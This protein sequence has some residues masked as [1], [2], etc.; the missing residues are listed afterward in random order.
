MKIV[1]LTVNYSLI[2]SGGIGSYLHTAANG[3]VSYGH[4]VTVMS[5]VIVGREDALYSVC[6]I[7]SNVD[8]STRRIALSKIFTHELLRLNDKTAI[9]I[10]EATD[11]GM[12]GYDCLN[13]DEFATIIRLHTPNS[14]VDE[15]NGY[16]RLKDSALVNKLE[17]E[18]FSKANYL[19]SPS[20]AMAVLA[21][22][23]W[24]V[25]IGKI[26]VIHNPVET[27][28]S[29]THRAVGANSGVIR[30]GFLGRLE[31]R[32]GVYVLAEALRSV[33]SETNNLEVCF[34]GPDTRLGDGS[35]GRNLRKS[36][37]PYTNKVQFTG[38]LGGSRKQDALE[39][40]D[41]I[42]LP[43]LWENFPYAC[44]EAMAA[45]KYVI[46]TSGSG[47]EEMITPGINGILV[48]PG[49]SKA[50][51]Q[52]I[53]DSLNRKTY[54]IGINNNEYVNNFQTKNIIPKMVEYYQ[55]IL[56]E[57]GRR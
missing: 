21:A 44:L 33:F 4:D 57:K 35:V 12:E 41:M 51:S 8:A 34:I 54:H 17:G 22:K 38:H 46:A 20:K 26:K 5:P 15:L 11:W 56:Q 49:D 14:V 48:S 53:I 42:V 16:S 28:T 31:P 27:A 24:N 37:R 32:K 29:R 52:A 19:S 1:F 30:L 18:Y 39:S 9:N 55:W 6:K 13:R 23:E 40:C 47:F 10:V 50:L 45:G 2:T 25:D 43:S 7:E 3:L 36:L